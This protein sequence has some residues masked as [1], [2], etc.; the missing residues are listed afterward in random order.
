MS[1]NRKKYNI[2]LLPDGA[3]YFDPQSG[4]VWVINRNHPK[5]HKGYVYE[6]RHVMEQHL[7]RYLEHDET[8]HHLNHRKHDNRIENLEVLPKG[9][10]CKINTKKYLRHFHNRFKIQKQLVASFDQEVGVLKPIYFF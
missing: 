4:Y 6:H 7:G 8:V 1:T 2:L 5:A 10:H 9:I 3:K